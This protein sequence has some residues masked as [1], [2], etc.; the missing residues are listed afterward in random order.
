MPFPPNFLDELRSRVGLASLVS[1]RVK[2]VQKG[3]EKLGLCPFHSEK[4]PSFTVSEEKGFYHCFGCGAHGDIVGFLM[5]IENLSFP[6]AVEKIADEAGVPVPTMSKEERGRA[7]RHASLLQVMEEACRFYQSNLR[8]PQG[9]PALNY[10]RG[11]G[12]D[13]E[14]INKFRLGYALD[15]RS[16]L[17]NALKSDK[18]SLNQLS[19]CGLLIKPDNGNNPFDRFR[20]RVMFPIL[21][22]RGRVIAFG[23]RTLD[24]IQPKYLNSPETPLFQ[25]GHI[26]YGLATAWRCAQEEKRL[27]V[28]EG[29]MD[30]IA[31]ARAGIKAVVAPLGTALTESQISLLWRVVQEPILCFDGDNAGQLAAVRVAER[32]LPLLKPGYSLRFVTMPKGEDPDT[33]IRTQGGGALE[34]LIASARPMDRLIWD[35]ESALTRLDTPERIAGLEQR[36]ERRS[37]T[38]L[39][40]KVQNQYL[41]SF[42]WRI[43][44]ETRGRLKTVRN[45][46]KPVIRTVANPTPPE[47]LRKRREQTVLATFINHWILMDEFSEIL[48]SSAFLDPMLDKLRQEILMLYTTSPELDSGGV[49]T[50]LV[51]GGFGDCLEIVLGPDVFIHAGFAAAEVELSVSRTGVIEVLD[52]LQEQIWRSELQ[53]AEEAYTSNPTPNNWLR[54]QECMDIAQKENQIGLVGLDDNGVVRYD[55]KESI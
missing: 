37:L 5:R 41:K 40:R 13:E 30:V 34:N 32:S 29:Y 51:E 19:E 26:L 53:D 25:K 47:A 39:N 15:S 46:A 49:K 4:T 55:I 1:R 21:D 17:K 35:M 11:R 45:Q 10:L 24:S 52:G 33:L 28:V 14:I 44:E 54:L 12:L 7:V 20:G 8:S 3:R 18:I 9:Q 48:G 31:L 38:I 43:Q 16:A 36:L 23:A 2:L 6:E 50:R 27:I 22:R 42:R